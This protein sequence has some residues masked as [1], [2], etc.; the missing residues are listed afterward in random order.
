[1]L[2]YQKA[3]L[4]LLAL[5]ARDNG[6]DEGTIKGIL[7]E[8]DNSFT[9]YDEYFNR[10]LTDY[11]REKLRVQEEKTEWQQMEQAEIVFA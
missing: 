2:R 10:R 4:K 7:H 8:A 3:Q 11:E 6:A 9:I 5:I 1:M